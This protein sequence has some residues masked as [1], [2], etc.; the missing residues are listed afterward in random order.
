MK[1]H[2]SIR[3]QSTPVYQGKNLVGRNFSDGA[4]LHI[5]RFG[6]FA[7]AYTLISADKNVSTK[8]GFKTAAAASRVGCGVWKK[9]K[10]ATEG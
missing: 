5:A 2:D 4:S 8:G 10:S 9:M 1:K 3:D 6:E 7:F